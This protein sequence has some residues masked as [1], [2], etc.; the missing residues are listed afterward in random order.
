M[1]RKP[2]TRIQI[3]DR[4]KKMPISYVRWLAGCYLCDMSAAR[5]QA[6][7]NDSDVHEF[8]TL[9]EE[10]ESLK[11]LL[12]AMQPEYDRVS[13]LEGLI[14]KDDWQIAKK[15]TTSAKR[16]NR[17]RARIM[18]LIKLPHVAALAKSEHRSHPDNT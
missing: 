7:I 13:K 2:M 14:S 11:K 17:C 6:Y 15:W 10:L 16:Y 9:A 5:C 3:R 4:I 1:A 8:A 18:E 12:D